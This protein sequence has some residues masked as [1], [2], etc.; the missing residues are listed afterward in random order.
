MDIL[1]KL[2]D[3]IPAKPAAGFYDYDDDCLN[4]SLDSGAVQCPNR[5][6]YRNLP[7]IGDDLW[8]YKK[9]YFVKILFNSFELSWI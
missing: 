7:F 1:D 5:S 4:Y 3:N 6:F 9:L 8:F 2:K